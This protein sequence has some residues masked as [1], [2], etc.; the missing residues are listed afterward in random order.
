MASRIIDFG[1][2]G[3]AVDRLIA[4]ALD[5]DVGP[6]DR[7]AE[8]CIDARARGSALIVAKEA[9]VVSGVSAAA[10]VFRALDPEVQLEALVGE[11]EDAQPGAGVLR[12]RGRL[13]A[14]LT[15]ERTALNLIQRLSGIA[16][17]ARRYVA[18]LA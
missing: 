2:R 5:E 13:R 7:T 9:M 16:T 15:A 11:G 1:R 10:R 4:L 14:L 6:G 12:A 3:D 8:A 17:Q 18:A